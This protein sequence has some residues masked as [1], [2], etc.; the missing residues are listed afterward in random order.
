MW[1]FSC[2]VTWFQTSGLDY[3]SLSIFP[4]HIPRCPSRP[5][6][7]NNIFSVVN[8]KYGRARKGA[9]SSALRW[10]SLLAPL[11]PPRS[12]CGARRDPAEPPPQ[13]L[14]PRGCAAAAPLP[15]AAPPSP[16]AAAGQR[17]RAAHAA[18][19]QPAPRRA[20][21]GRGRALPRGP[22]AA[23]RRRLRLGRPGDWRPAEGEAE[24]ARP[25]HPR[26]WQVRRQMRAP[27]SGS[28]LEGATC[29]AVRALQWHPLCGERSPPR[30]STC[31]RLS[32]E[33]EVG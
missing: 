2:E 7:A 20:E 10:N 12:L 32:T 18:L 23:E 8:V 19:W 5:P 22:V 1:L 4:Y 24:E 6:F 33:W 17:P 21:T 30:P 3:V 15:A 26:P 14:L 9:S 16:P 29:P 31:P 27:R 13:P 25:L 28:A 11:F